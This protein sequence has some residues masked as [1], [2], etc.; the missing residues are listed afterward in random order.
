MAKLTQCDRVLR[1]LE[2]FGSITSLEA[3]TEYGIMRLASRIADLKAQGYAIESERVTGKNRYEE[4]TNYS[5]YRLV[6]K[7]VTTNA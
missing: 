7:E 1:H 4:T 2:D 6:N 5:V 3:M